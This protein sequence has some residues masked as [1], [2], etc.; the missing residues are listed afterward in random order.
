MNAN[1]RSL[2]A[3]YIAKAAAIADTFR[4]YGLKVYLSANFAAPRTIGGLATAD[5]LDPAV[6]Q[7]VEGQGGARSTRRSPTSA[8]SW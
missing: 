5:P 3:E 2:T 8:A 7:L 1:A 4:P 6:Q